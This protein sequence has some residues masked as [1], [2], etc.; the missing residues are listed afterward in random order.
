MPYLISSILFLSSAVFMSFCIILVLHASS[1]A[2]CLV[3]ALAALHPLHPR[4]YPYCAM[5]VS[6]TRN[7]ISGIGLTWG[8]S[9][10]D[11]WFCFDSQLELRAGGRSSHANYCV[12]I[13]SLVPGWSS[14]R[15]RSLVS[16]RSTHHDCSCF[17][18]LSW[19]RTRSSHRTLPFHNL[20]RFLV[21]SPSV[22]FHL[23][24]LRTC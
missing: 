13:P 8:R 23:D 12:C 7:G 16:V 14:K 2:C 21:P 24:P 5:S 17:C 15:P 3:P 10:C 19:I 22:S 20:L 9:A 18:T 6:I 11:L 1:C 4:V